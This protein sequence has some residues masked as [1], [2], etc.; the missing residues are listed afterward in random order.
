MSEHKVAEER[1]NHLDGVL[2]NMHAVTVAGG[3]THL[4]ALDLHIRA[5]MGI[6][7]DAKG[8]MTEALNSVETYIGE[9]IKEMRKQAQPI[10]TTIVE[11]RKI[12]RVQ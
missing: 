2:A 9:V 6:A 11:N 5:A 4:E 3:L 7:Y 10:I 8:N 1:D 12:H